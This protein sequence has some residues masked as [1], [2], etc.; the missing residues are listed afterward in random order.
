MAGTPAFY[1]HSK[2]GN[3]ERHDLV[4]EEHYALT[5]GVG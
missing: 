1:A 3:G 2:N 5:L 4:T